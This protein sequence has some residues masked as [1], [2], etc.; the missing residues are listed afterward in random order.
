[1][2][3]SPRPSIDGS[4]AYGK[5]G[6]RGAMGSPNRTPR[7]S[8]IST[9][10]KQA[11]NLP[12]FDADAV[13]KLYNEYA[14]SSDAKETLSLVVI[15]HV[16][17]GKSTL[18]GHLLV[19]IGHV[20]KKLMHRNEVDSKK[21]GKASFL[22]AWALDETE[23]ERTRGI[24]MDVAEQTFETDHRRVT[25]LDAPGH[26]DFIPNMITGA[27]VAD[28]AILVI[29]STKGEF[30]TGFDEG[31]QTREHTLLVRSLGVKQLIVAVNKL[32]TCRWSRDRYQEISDKLMVFLK[33]ANFRESD[34]RFV[35]VSGLVGENLTS[36]SQVPDLRQW[37]DGPCLLELID[38]FQ[39][40]ERPVARPLRIAITDI[41]KG[42]ATAGTAIGGRVLTGCVSQGQK[43]LVQPAAEFCT[44]KSKFFIFLSIFNY[45]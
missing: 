27:A 11:A 5:R 20:S 29:D 9:P 15:G 18:M 22:Y 17:A 6:S 30:E 10:A 38:T 34:I 31:G 16:D 37:Y 36:R 25:L 19:K 42:G 13:M 28:A 39:P 4:L 40:P 26:K 7:A 43:C 21:S 14:A 32:D 3:I 44:V 2:T 33:Q 35:P 8:P 1:M 24:T 23:E 12:K 41:F 45:L